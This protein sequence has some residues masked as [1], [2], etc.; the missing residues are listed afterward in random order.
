MKTAKFVSAYLKA[1][2]ITAPRTVTVSAVELVE[3]RDDEKG[4]TRQSLCIGFKELDQLVV[5]SKTSLGQLIEIMG[6][7]ESDNWIG[8]KVV[9][10]N[11]ESVMFHGK[12][13]GGLRFR[14]VA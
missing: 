8:K 12:R 9:L 14:K 7:D 11:D 6:T 1:K 4:G 10:F 3:F 5:T 2:D 13:C